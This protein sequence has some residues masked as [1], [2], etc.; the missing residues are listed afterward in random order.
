M[1]ENVLTIDL[2]EEYKIKI[3]EPK[4]L[5]NSFFKDIYIRAAKATADILKQSE[6]NLVKAKEEKFFINQHQEYNNIIA[7]CGER[8]TGKS[9]AMISFAKGLLNIDDKSFLH[10]ESKNPEIDLSKFSFKTID[11]I[12]PSL[13]EKGE[14]IFEVILAQ[15]FS[16]FEKEIKKND[17]KK[18]INDKRKVLELFEN[19]YE[20]L[21]T[22]KKNGQKYDGEALETLSKLACG[23]NLRENFKELV[24]KYLEFVSEKHE[25][26]ALIIAI[27]DFDLNVEAVAEMAEQIRKY[28]MIPKVIILMAANMKQ[29]TNAKEQNIRKELAILIDANSLSESPNDISTKYLIKL[30][31]NNRRLNLPN[32]EN[33]LKDTTLKII[34]FDKEENIE[35]LVKQVQTFNTKWLIKDKNI[36]EYILGLIYNKTGLIFL[37]K[38]DH[39][40]IL[41]PTN[42][43][44]LKGLLSHLCRECN[45]NR[46]NNFIKFRDNFYSNVL[47]EFFSGELLNLLR[48]IITSEPGIMNK[49]V[50]TEFKNYLLKEYL[51]RYSPTHEPTKQQIFKIESGYEFDNIISERNNPV[52]ISLG[53]ILFFLK[54]IE[55]KTSNNHHKLLTE[56]IRI[57]YSLELFYLLFIKKSKKSATLICGESIIP[58]NHAYVPSSKQGFNRNNFRLSIK[59]VYYKNNTIKEYLTDFETCKEI[60]TLSFSFKHYGSEYLERR[61]STSSNVTS[62]LVT[63]INI[64]NPTTVHYDLLTFLITSLNP[65]R[66]LNRFIDLNNEKSDPKSLLEKYPLF[67]STIEFNDKYTCC[68]PIFSIELIEKIFKDDFDH[69]KYNFDY[70]KETLYSAQVNI[71][72][73][74]K[75][76]IK[77]LNY[78][79]LNLIEIQKTFE[80]C[81]FIKEY[82]PDNNNLNTLY[83]AIIVEPKE[84]RHSKSEIELIATL[85]EKIKA[86]KNDTSLGSFRIDNLAPIKDKL[87]NILNY[88]ILANYF[89][90]TTRFT[91]ERKSTALKKID[92]AV[93]KYNKIHLDEKPNEEAYIQ[94]N[95]TSIPEQATIMIDKETLI[96]IEDISRN[97]DSFERNELIS[98]PIKQEDTSSEEHAVIDHNSEKGKNTE[99]QEQENE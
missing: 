55:S 67:K 71:L 30:I 4:D 78:K 7:F 49:V 97:E 22:I 34:P 28:L 33:S 14:N 31:P 26:P 29:L 59:D 48:K 38:N 52:N 77:R 99:L 27:D 89:K 37:S 50:I 3:E 86:A 69:V 83:N 35:T 73:E 24:N 25:I 2:N 5:S 68:F 39:N 43:R 91:N 45:G 47:P 56:V 93:E 6:D 46:N 18:D 61:T 94:E 16:S 11:V 40:H 66:L 63:N 23:A 17:T 70:K 32:I 74:I 36:E 64:F 10:S 19:V 76:R 72:Q 51:S 41:I 96:N 1:S 62:K 87:D 44:K 60:Q 84:T 21:Q 98:S 95:T 57:I 58:H 80:E 13:F 85:K 79:Y 82:N 81:P 9:S 53:D 42:L 75:K 12:D 54:E 15:L 65:I 88:D 90:R 20:N 8:G 92:E